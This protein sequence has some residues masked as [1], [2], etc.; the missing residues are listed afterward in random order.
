VSAAQLRSHEILSPLEITFDAMSRLPFFSVIVPTHKRAGLL[1][2][3]L[4]SVKS[5]ALPA[6][7]EVIVVSD[8]IDVCT[9]TVCADVLTNDDIYIRRN[10][11]AG[12]SASRNLALS[13]AKGKYVLFLD[14]DDAWHPDCL[15]HL[16]AHLGAHGSVPVYFN[17][18][19]V[20][21]RRLPEGT[22]QLSEV[23]LDLAGRLTDE[24]Y[25]KNQVHMSCFAF[26]RSLLQ[27]IEFD[28]FMRAY[29]D[30]EY[31]LSVFD[32]E[33]PVHLPLLGSR[34]FEVND[35]TTDRRGSSP[36]ATDFN[37]VFDYLYV[38]RRHPA[39]RQELS[40]QRAALLNSFGIPATPDM[41]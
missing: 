6:G 24:V 13:L 14:D 36:N 9:D 7:M 3:A 17:C 40:L 33:L 1:R 31:L 38:Y 22:E 35:E 12:P 21:E 34:V 30:W 41:L 15:Q 26:P 18:S 4:V 8:A 28:P 23:G 20:R 39:P 16:Y 27:G 25:V 2:R 10:G 29:E 37:A 19:V 5:Q 32:R 11:P